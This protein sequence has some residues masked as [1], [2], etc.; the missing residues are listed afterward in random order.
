MPRQVL[1]ARRRCFEDKPGLPVVVRDRRKPALERRDLESEA[2]GARR[3]I[4]SHDE[5]MGGNGLRAS[6]GAVCREV[7]PIGRVRLD[8]VS[9]RARVTGNL[10]LADLRSICSGE[11]KPKPHVG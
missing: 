4:G 1:R 5:R 3:Q 8:R 2:V 7:R 9:R 6:I 10:G 11:S